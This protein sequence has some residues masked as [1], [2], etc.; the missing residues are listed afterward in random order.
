MLTSQGFKIKLFPNQFKI[1]ITLFY[2]PGY[3]QMNLP[4]GVSRL[5]L[6]SDTKLSSML[7]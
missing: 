6:M 4:A 1:H 5:T 7:T 3:A 2:K